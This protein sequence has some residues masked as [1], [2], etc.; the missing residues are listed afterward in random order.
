MGQT[1]IPIIINFFLF[2][3]TVQSETVDDA[4]I[5][6]EGLWSTFQSSAIAPNR[7]F[8][9][10]DQFGDSAQLT[11]NG[12]RPPPTPLPMP[13]LT[14]SFEQELQFPFMA[15][16]ISLPVVITLRSTEKRHNIMPSRCGKKAPSCFI[17][18]DSTL[19]GPT[20]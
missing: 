14:V 13:Q 7:R 12:E 20:P 9:V 19:S 1:I 4:S 8:H 6:Y 16:E 5:V 17:P 15:S 11:F 3:L 10:T 18:P 2:S